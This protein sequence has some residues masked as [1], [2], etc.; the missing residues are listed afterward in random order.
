VPGMLFVVSYYLPLYLN[1]TRDAIVIFML[2]NIMPVSVNSISLAVKCGSSAEYAA[3]GV[4]FTHVF[5][6]A[7]MT[8]FIV[9]IEQM[10]MK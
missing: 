1:A 9:F 7:T 2:V 3:Q 4:V 10:L 6:I 8:V 5:A